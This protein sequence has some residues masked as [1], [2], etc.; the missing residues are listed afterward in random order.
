MR[1]LMNEKDVRGMNLKWKSGVVH[2]PI[3]KLNFMFRGPDSQ[4]E[5]KRSFCEE[6]IKMTR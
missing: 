5:R 1:T 3:L 4:I 6:R 2:N